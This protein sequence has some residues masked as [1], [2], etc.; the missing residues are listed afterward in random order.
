MLLSKTCGFSYWTPIRPN[1][2]YISVVILKLSISMT[3]GQHNNV[4]RSDIYSISIIVYRII[5]TI[6]RT[7]SILNIKSCAW[8]RM[9]FL[10]Y[11][12]IFTSAMKKI[13]KEGEGTEHIAS[14]FRK[15]LVESKSTVKLEY[16]DRIEYLSNSATT[17]VSPCSWKK[18][19]YNG[20]C[21]F[22]NK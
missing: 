11:R 3:N 12:Q 4:Y 13:Q 7:I 22:T 2:H 18:N 10:G 6:R 17:S 16:G 5:S 1:T 15:L 21:F 19:I 20:L 8:F 9:C 14:Y